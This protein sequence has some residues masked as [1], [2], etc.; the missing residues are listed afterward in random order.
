MKETGKIYA[1]KVMNKNQ[2]MEFP[3]VFKLI[4]RRRQYEHTL[5]ERRIMQD[6]SHPFLVW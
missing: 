2:I 1:M 5:S 6:I 4:S 3:C